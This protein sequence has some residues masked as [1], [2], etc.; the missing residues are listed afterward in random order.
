MRELLG[1]GSDTKFS[2]E[3]FF[4]LVDKTFLVP[5]ITVIHGGGVIQVY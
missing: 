1:N 4:E 5:S 3:E 2:L